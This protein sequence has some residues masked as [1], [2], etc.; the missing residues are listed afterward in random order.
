VLFNQSPFKNYNIHSVFNL[1][2]IVSTRPERFQE[3]FLYTFQI[4]LLGLILKYQWIDKKIDRDSLVTAIESFLH[5]RD[6]QMRR[7]DSVDSCKILGIFRTS[8][9][10][11]RRVVVTVSGTPNSLAVE[12][13]TGDQTHSILKFGSLISFFGGGSL[14]LKKQRSADFY[15]KF[16]DEFWHH[17]ESKVS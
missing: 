1:L 14:L 2:V 3:P 15:Q 4:N 16:E 5:A 11:I 12:L 13:I 6:F 8:E 9:D 7:E 10:E 17:L